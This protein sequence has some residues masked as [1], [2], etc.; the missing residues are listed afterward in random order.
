MNLTPTILIGRSVDRPFV[1][2]QL[3]YL[4]IG[5]VNDGIEQ[6]CQSNAILV[7]GRRSQVEVRFQRYI[8]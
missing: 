5:F 4:W 6:W 2:E 3:G 1:Q 7:V 8:V